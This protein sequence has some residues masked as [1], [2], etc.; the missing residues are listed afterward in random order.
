MHLYIPYLTYGCVLWSN[1]YEAPLSELLRLQNKAIR[2]INN[3]SLHDHI[4]PHY[5]NLDLIKLP[6]I[7]KLYICQLHV[8]YDHLID[9]KLLN[10][11]L[12]L[13]SVSEQHNYATRSASLQHLHPSFSRINIK[14]FCPTVIGCYYWNDLPLSIHTVTW[15]QENILKKALYQYYFAQY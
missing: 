4:T 7:V 12:S 2:I 14:K 11:T 6:D 10:Y 3:V 8:L 1:N 15:Q 5:V 13:V 9:E